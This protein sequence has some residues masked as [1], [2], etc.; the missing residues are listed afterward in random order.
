MK[1]INL[2][3]LVSKPSIPLSNSGNLDIIEGLKFSLKISSYFGFF[4]S[5][6]ISFTQELGGI[7]HTK[8]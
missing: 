5:Y 6:K 8:K 1:S 7:P 2:L 4:V 3:S